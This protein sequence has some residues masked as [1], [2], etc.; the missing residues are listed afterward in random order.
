MGVCV[1]IVEER[2]RA[3]DERYWLLVRLSVPVRMV[4]WGR[5]DNPRQPVICQ[6]ENQIP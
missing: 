3:W 5:F 2:C 4:C 6:P 1:C